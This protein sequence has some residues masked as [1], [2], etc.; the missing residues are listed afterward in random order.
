MRGGL[1]EVIQTSVEPLHDKERESRPAQEADTNELG[2]VGVAD[3]GHQTTLVEEVLRYSLNSSLLI[4]FKKD[5]VESLYCIFSV[6]DCHLRGR[7]IN[8][9]M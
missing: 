5:F 4:R 8:L 3:L 7:D 1:Q 9:E 2:D 6:V